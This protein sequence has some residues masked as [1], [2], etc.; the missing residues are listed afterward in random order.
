M[1]PLFAGLNDRDPPATLGTGWLVV[2][3]NIVARNERA[4]SPAKL[5][6]GMT[7]LAN[8]AIVT[9]P[10]TGLFAFRS[11]DEEKILYAAPT[12]KLYCSDDYATALTLAKTWTW[13]SD[14]LWQFLVWRDQ[15][16]AVNGSDD[17]GQFGTNLRIQ[18]SNDTI[19]PMSV[20]I[21]TVAPTAAENGFGVLTGE[22]SWFY[23]FYDPTLDRESNASTI[24]TKTPAAKKMLIT[25][26]ACPDATFTHFRIYRTLTGGD[27]YFRLV[28]QAV[29]TGLTYDDNVTDLAV[30]LESGYGDAG[31]DV[32]DHAPTCGAICE[33][34]DGRIALGDDIENAKHKRIYVCYDADHPEAFPV[35]NRLTA[36][37]ENGAKILVMLPFGDQTAVIC[38]D[39]IWVINAT[40]TECEY[41]LPNGGV[42]RHC[43]KETPYGIIF[44][45]RHGVYIFTG[46]A[47][48]RLS[49]VL[50][51][52]WATIDRDWLPYVETAYDSELDLFLVAVCTTAGGAQN[53][54]ILALDCRTLDNRDERGYPEP[55]WS[56]WPYVRAEGLWSCQ[57]ARPG[58]SKT[59]LGV[60]RGV[61]CELD[62]EVHQD[63][64]ASGTVKSTVT[65]ATAGT[66]TDSGAAFRTAGDGLMGCNVFITEG[67]GTG[68]TREITS[69]TATALT[70]ASNWTTTPDATSEYQ[71]GAIPVRMHS[72][73]FTAGAPSHYKQFKEVYVYTEQP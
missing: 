50:D 12:T 33:L 39:G 20:K 54:T 36:G 25:V 49:S 37:A 5:R 30:S 28:T 73:E 29:A 56:V 66:L 58:D 45:G 31:D 23:T 1:L 53:D 44:V 61:L 35:A 32:W 64:V 42:G 27:E 55:R 38:E 51:G 69:N 60:G 11:G 68:Q 6:P 22:Y 7:R 40:C 65:S 43:G 9:T 14:D 15:V 67:T 72:G 2:A 34:P 24:V 18:L 8:T 52:T 46:Y 57:A 26:A 63:A 71:V 70:L 41:R 10:C 4:D 47:V 59:F 48:Y 62:D 17:A 3:E 16:Y 21:P 13:Q 19:Y